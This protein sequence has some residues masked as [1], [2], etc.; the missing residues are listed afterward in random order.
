MRAQSPR[1]RVAF[2]RL[3]GE[4]A[5][6][7][8]DFLA[9]CPVVDAAHCRASMNDSR[10]LPSG[11]LSQLHPIVAGRDHPERKVGSDLTRVGSRNINSARTLHR[12]LDGVVLVHGH[13]IRGG[14]GRS[15][16]NRRT[17]GYLQKPN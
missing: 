2:E 5:Q 4:C 12:E 14:K 11:L 15:V 1:K 6:V 13:G 17:R 8:I 10:A 7:E 16:A 9:R 3:C